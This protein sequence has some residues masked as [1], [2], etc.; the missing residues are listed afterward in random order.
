MSEIEKEIVPFGDEYIPG[1]DDEISA[2]SSAKNSSEESE[3]PDFLQEFADWAAIQKFDVTLTGRQ[4]GFLVAS[5]VVQRQQAAM[6]L[7]GDTLIESIMAI[8]SA[9]EVLMPAYQELETAWHSA[10]PSI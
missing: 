10:I 3:Q 2:G 1:G 5:L 7:S 6:S 4:L 8:E 9:L